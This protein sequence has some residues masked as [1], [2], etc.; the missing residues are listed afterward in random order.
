MGKIQEISESEVRK[1]EPVAPPD[2]AE[3]RATPV[4]I[5]LPLSIVKPHISLSDNFASL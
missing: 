3:Q 1:A 4:S 5:V 2:V